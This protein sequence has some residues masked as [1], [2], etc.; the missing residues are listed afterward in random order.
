MMI[1]SP[2]TLKGKEVVRGWL[3]KEEEGRW[4]VGEIY[5]CALAT[6]SPHRLFYGLES[7][8]VM[9]GGR[10]Q[11]GEEVNIEKR[12]RMRGGQ[13]G[14]EVDLIETLNDLHLDSESESDLDSDSGSG[15]NLVLDLDLDLDNNSTFQ[16]IQ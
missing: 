3:W 8:L 15:S 14:G 13:V 12:P 16:R 7:L 9:E 5:T 6:Q 11:D 4:I 1:G 2:S 10:D